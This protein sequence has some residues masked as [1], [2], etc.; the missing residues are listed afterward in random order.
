MSRRV[1]PICCDRILQMELAP[2]QRLKEEDYGR[3][4]RL[5][6]RGSIDA[7]QAL[8]L[9]I[10][11]CWDLEEGRKEKKRSIGHALATSEGKEL[12]DFLSLIGF[13]LI[14]LQCKQ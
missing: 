1:S 2:I 11:D 8:L 7:L 13:E 4:Y 10:S 3:S 5:K 6:F 14:L 12:F 9:H